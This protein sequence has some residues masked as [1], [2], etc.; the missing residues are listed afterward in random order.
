MFRNGL[1]VSKHTFLSA[2]REKGSVIFCPGGQAELVH[3]WKAFLP[4]DKRQVVLHTRHKGF[5]RCDY[6]YGMSATVG[7]Q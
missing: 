6:L 3:A 4:R 2:L 7:T 5:C 1:Q